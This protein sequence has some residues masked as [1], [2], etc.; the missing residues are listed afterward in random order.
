MKLCNIC[1]PNYQSKMSRQLTE[2]RMTYEKVISQDRQIFNLKKERNMLLRELL[3]TKAISE[4][5]MLLWLNTCAIS[6]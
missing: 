6:I 5:T 4:I 3:E 2:L 1:S